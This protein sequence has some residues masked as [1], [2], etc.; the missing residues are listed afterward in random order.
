VSGWRIRW[1]NAGRAAAIAAAALAA[2]AV[3]P[4]L[5]GGSEPPPLP[6]DVGLAPAATP[7]TPLPAQPP[8]PP[9]PVGS[10]KTP[11]P[12]KEGKR[13]EKGSGRIVKRGG[14]DSP[15]QS[16]HPDSPPSTAPGPS[17]PVYAYPVAPTPPE[18][19]FER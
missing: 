16:D 2:I 17:A 4:S 5:L 14:R 7:A 3:L 18:F 13:R 8:P 12:I 15:R 11:K 19:S 1:S 9:L 10:Q 6:A